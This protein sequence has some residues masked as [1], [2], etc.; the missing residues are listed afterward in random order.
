MSKVWNWVLNS[1][2]SVSQHFHKKVNINGL[3]ALLGI[4]LLF[5]ASL[6]FVRQRWYTLFL[7]CHIVGIFLFLIFVSLI[8]LSGR[9]A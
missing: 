7:F 4:E 1:K 9:F 8:S 6:P 3:V 5:F 2:Q